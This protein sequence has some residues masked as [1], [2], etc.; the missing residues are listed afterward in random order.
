MGRSVRL[1]LGQWEEVKANWLVYSVESAELLGVAVW[2]LHMT[3]DGWGLRMKSYN[4]CSGRKVH[5][6]G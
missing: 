6:M 3:P 4:R 1:L 2:L 5:S